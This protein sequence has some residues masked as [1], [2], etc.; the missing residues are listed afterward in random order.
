MISPN[1]C[2]IISPYNI[3]TNRLAGQ[4]RLAV[5]HAYNH[6]VLNY[7]RTDKAVCKSNFVIYFP[8]K[9][10]NDNFYEFTDSRLIRC[11]LYFREAVLLRASVNHKVTA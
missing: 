11:T 6:A 1:N 7:N 5:H 2:Y 10:E 4:Q 9:D 3:S 8:V